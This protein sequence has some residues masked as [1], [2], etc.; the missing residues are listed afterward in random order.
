MSGKRGSVTRPPTR[1]AARIIRAVRKAGGD[2]GLT[3]NGHL[4]VVGP[5]G[6]STVVGSKYGCPRAFRNA[7]SKIRNHTGMALG[8]VP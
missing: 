5:D 7:M 2:V 4:R 8:L 1:D 3:A 6:R